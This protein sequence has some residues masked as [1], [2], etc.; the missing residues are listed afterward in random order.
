MTSDQTR[1]ISEALMKAKNALLDAL[2]IAEG[3]DRPLARRIDSLAGRVEA[4]QHKH[5]QRG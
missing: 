1:Q 5:T 3:T 4:L 2:R